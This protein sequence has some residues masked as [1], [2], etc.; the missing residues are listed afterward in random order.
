MALALLLVALATAAHRVPKECSFARSKKAG[1]PLEEPL[2]L[3]WDPWTSSQL[4]TTIMGMLLQQGL[5]F[6]VELVE[7][8]AVWK[9]SD[10]AGL[11]EAVSTGALHAALEVWP[12]AKSAQL[13]QFGSYDLGGASNRSEVTRYTN[14]VGRSGIYET[15]RRDSLSALGSC[16]DPLASA[17]PKML[18]DALSIGQAGVAHF[19]HTAHAPNAGVGTPTSAAECNIGL[20]CD[21]NIW[22]PPACAAERNCSVQL[23]HIWH[24][25]YD[26]GRIEQMIA[27]L[28]LPIEVAYVGPDDWARQVGHSY[29]TGQGGLFY[30]WY[31][32]GPVAGIPMEKFKRATVPFGD[33]LPEALLEKVH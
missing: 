11:Y 23:Q 16:T 20:G 25:A 33:D 21:G 17:L 31:P 9:N 28:G 32:H 27:R 4:L 3:S 6:N 26:K 22:R 13:S 14:L 2:R 8:S 7:L 12:Q 19:S 29:R 15:C 24:T 10:T 30:S 5:G 18:T 1:Q